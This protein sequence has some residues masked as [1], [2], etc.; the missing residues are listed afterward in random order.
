M[1][2]SK[3]YTSVLMKEINTLAIQNVNIQI[4]ILPEFPGKKQTKCKWMYLK[5]EIPDGKNKMCLYAKV[6]SICYV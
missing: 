6:Y 1:K 4:N 2:R 5:P 3:I